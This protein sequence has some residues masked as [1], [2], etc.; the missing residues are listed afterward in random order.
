MNIKEVM[1]SDKVDFTGIDFGYSKS[2]T[3]NINFCYLFGSYAK[4]KETPASDID[5]LISANVK[6]LKFYVL[7]EELRLTFRKKYMF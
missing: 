7:V 5:L 6:V 3:T 4:G 2:S 1:N